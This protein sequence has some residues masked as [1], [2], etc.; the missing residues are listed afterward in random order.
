MDDT[1]IIVR[2]CLTAD[3]VVALE[4]IALRLQKTR[5][6]ALRQIFLRYVDLNDHALSQMIRG[7][8]TSRGKPQ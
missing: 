4:T 8:R 2:C 6:D 3:E 5:E 1:T 7:S